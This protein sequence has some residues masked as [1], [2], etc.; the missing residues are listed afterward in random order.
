MNVVIFSN[1]AKLISPDIVLEWLSFESETSNTKQKAG[2]VRQLD[3]Y[4]SADVNLK[5]GKI[6]VRHNKQQKERIVVMSDGFQWLIRVNPRFLIN[7]VNFC[8]HFGYYPF[9][10]IS[11]ILALFNSKIGPDFK[12]YGHTAV[13]I[14]RKGRPGGYISAL[15]E[16]IL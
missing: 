14:G 15:F 4:L 5:S 11:K 9:H 16:N 8:M 3:K 2:I 13:R 7:Q 10:F 12:Q 6:I 1:Q